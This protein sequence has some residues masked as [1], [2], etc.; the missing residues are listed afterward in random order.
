VRSRAEPAR[1]R[2]LKVPGASRGSSPSRTAAR[3]KTIAAN[4]RRGGHAHEAIELLW[5]GEEGR[6]GALVDPGYRDHAAESVER[7]PALFASERRLLRC[8]FADVAVTSH[9]FVIAGEH[10][11]ARLHFR[12]LHVGP[13]AGLE[14]CG[15]TVEWDEIH[16]WRVHDGRL[17]EHW[18]CRDDLAAL[19]RL[20][21][22]LHWPS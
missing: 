14:P 19:C 2:G 22:A 15:R 6:V 20:G 7:G 12:G 21:A 9:E 5:G 13:Y 8:A 3:P 4:G 10:A 11:A 16:L 18:V 1:A 17:A